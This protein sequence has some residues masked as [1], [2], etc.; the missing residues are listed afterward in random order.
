VESPGSLVLGILTG[1][2]ALGHLIRWYRKRSCGGSDLKE[3]VQHNDAIVGEMPPYPKHYPTE[4]TAVFSSHRAIELQIHEK[5]WAD[6][7]K[8]RD[9]DAEEWRIRQWYI[10][11]MTDFLQKDLPGIN[12]R[13]D[14]VTREDY[15]RFLVGSM[16]VIIMRATTDDWRSLEAE[17]SLLDRKK[18][19]GYT[20]GEEDGTDESPGERPGEVRPDGQV[21]E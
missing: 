15:A 5:Q 4:G 18:P 6:E 10:Y 20:G 19:E 21:P 17:L 16:N 7:R 13:E 9:E 1:L 14:Y 8:T 3:A 12:N 2:L 11:R